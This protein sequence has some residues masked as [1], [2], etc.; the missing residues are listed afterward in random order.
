MNYRM[1]LYITGKIMSIGAVLLTAPMLV[2]VIY[3]EHSILAFAVTMA[4]FLAAGLVGV[5][6]KPKNTSIYAREGMVIVALSWVL[7]SF[8]GGLPFFISRE[9]PNIVDCFF[10]TASG[11]TTT[12][13]TILTNVEGLSHGMLFWRSFTH[14]IGGMGVLVFA[15]V[16]FAQKDT[17][18]SYIMR[19]EM[20][21]PQVGKLGEKWQFTTRTLYIIY[22]VMSIIEFILLVIGKMPV[23]DSLLHTFG[24]AGTGGF[25]VKNASIGYY[26]S[27]YIDYVI[28]IFMLLF[29]VN[30]N[31]YYLLL[32]RKISKIYANDEIKAYIGIVLCATV[33]VAFNILP[34]YGGFGKAFRFSLFQV[35]S[36]MTTTGFGTADF[37]QWP[38]LSQAILV[39]LMLIGSCA[40]STGGGLKVI[41]IVILAKGS[42]RDIGHAIYPRRVNTLK[43]DKKPIDAAVVSGVFSYFVIYMIIMALSILIVSI[44]NFDFTTTF[45]SVTATLNNIGPG[46]GAVGP[47]GNFAGYSM[48]SKVVLSFDMLAGRL[49]L[50]PMLALIM[51]SVWKKV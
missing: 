6:L 37:A 31:L 2:S 8:I 43:V 4:V 30:F 29:G 46:L 50:Y 10:E 20:P 41:R 28:S 11:F 13:S 36:I 14:W 32:L 9:I 16:L 19:A 24:T 48:L 45:T 35:S 23:F 39:L 38:V 17:R 34:I 15:N 21:G 51:P 3:G 27:A 40:G 12:G 7:F 49:E 22:F 18:M 44:D 33:I 47:T 42:L 26:N 5:I 1:V 25:G